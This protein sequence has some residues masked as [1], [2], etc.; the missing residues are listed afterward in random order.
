MGVHHLK[1]YINLLQNEM[2]KVYFLTTK[3]KVWQVKEIVIVQVIVYMFIYTLP[4]KSL[5]NRL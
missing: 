4:D 3:Y 2:D 1:N 5:R